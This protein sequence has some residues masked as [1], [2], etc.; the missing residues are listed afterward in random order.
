MLSGSVVTRENVLENLV[1]MG[2]SSEKIEAWKNDLR[3]NHT[4]QTVIYVEGMIRFLWSGQRDAS[5]GEPVPLLD[6]TKST[7]NPE[8]SGLLAQYWE[9]AM[10]A[11]VEKG[12]RELC[13][14]LALWTHFLTF[15]FPASLTQDYVKTVIMSTVPG[16][17]AI[18]SKPRTSHPK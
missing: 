8:F 1:L 12:D 7:A 9:P 5:T 13:C 10:I 4:I 15:I 6:N 14:L 16:L 17:R 3:G 2:M 11:A 18:I